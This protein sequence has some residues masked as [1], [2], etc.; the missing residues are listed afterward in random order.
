[1]LFHSWP[2]AHCRCV[3]WTY[4]VRKTN[5]KES[6]RDQRNSCVYSHVQQTLQIYT[7]NG[8]W[9]KSNGTQRKHHYRR[10]WSNWTSIHDLN[11]DWNYHCCL[12]LLLAQFTL[13]VSTDIIIDIFVKINW[14]RIQ[15]SH[16]VHWFIVLGV[17]RDLDFA[18][19]GSFFYCITV[20]K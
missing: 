19:K 13:W 1:M 8:L 10:R 3:Q 16:R 15:E 11:V 9:R 18:I 12:T 2:R 14:L 7:M 4:R 17:E 5:Y 6:I 20:R